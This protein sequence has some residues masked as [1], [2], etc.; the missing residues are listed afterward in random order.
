MPGSALLPGDTPHPAARRRFPV[1]TP[2]RSS[3]TRDATRRA[4]RRTSTSPPRQAQRNP[5]P[6]GRVWQRGSGRDRPGRRTHPTGSTAMPGTTGSCGG[7]GN[8]LVEGGRGDDALAGGRGDDDLAG[9][10]GDDD[11]DGGAGADR[12]DGGTGGDTLTGGRGNDLLV[13]G[14]GDDT[15]L[16]DSGDGIDTIVDADGLGRIVVD[17]RVLAVAPPA[18]REWNL[19]QPR[20][21]RHVPLQRRCA[22]GRRVGDYRGRRFEAADATFWL[23]DGIRVRGFRNGDLGLTFGDGSAAALAAG[24]G[25]RRDRRHRPAA[26]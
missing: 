7:A 23:G 26:R 24:C 25:R 13:G 5:Q 9:G 22:A 1:R 6:S 2:G 10:R 17:D 21:R 16:F 8:D 18:S 11:L 20:R 4:S 14:R 15:Y 3:T 19:A 12:L